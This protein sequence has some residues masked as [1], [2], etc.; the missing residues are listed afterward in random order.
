MCSTLNLKSELV[1]Q[2]AKVEEPLAI[3]TQL[4]ICRFVDNTLIIVFFSTRIIFIAVPLHPLSEASQYLKKIF[5]SC[6]YLI[7]CIL[8]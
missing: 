4:F 8:R 1:A 2:N 6:M 3:A 5:N 7:M